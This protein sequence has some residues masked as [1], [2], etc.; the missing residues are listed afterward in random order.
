MLTR[1]QADEEIVKRVFQCLAAYLDNPALGTDQFAEGALLQAAFHLFVS[2]QKTLSI[3]TFQSLPGISAS[4]H[5]AATECIVSAAIIA[6]DYGVH[7]ALAKSLQRQ[8]YAL[9]DSYN[10][11]VAR[12]DLYQ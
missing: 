3:L 9:V 12:D 11:A 6:E 1:F 7:L 4:L 8:T 10:S 2:S 5:D